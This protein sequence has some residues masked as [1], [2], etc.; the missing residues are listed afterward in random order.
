[1]SNVVRLGDGSAVDPEDAGG[2]LFEPKV[3]ELLEEA[4]ANAKRGEIAAVGIIMVSPTGRV[5]PWWANPG[6]HGH[7]LVA[8]CEYLKRGIHDRLVGDSEEEG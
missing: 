4:L 6:A 3:V 7:T 2:H 8:G 1:M 5:S